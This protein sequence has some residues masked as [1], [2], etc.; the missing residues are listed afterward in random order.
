MLQGQL[1]LSYVPLTISCS[2]C[3]QEQVVHVQDRGGFW[4]TAHQ[5]VK[6]LKC[7]RE[8]EVMLPEAIVTGPFL[9]G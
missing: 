4:S 2:H 7:K 1:T 5:W 3:Q 6:C 9:Q 8:F